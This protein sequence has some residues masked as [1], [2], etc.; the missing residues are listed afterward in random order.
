MDLMPYVLEGGTGEVT[1]SLPP[2]PRTIEVLC[3]SPQQEKRLRY[4]LRM[5]W[6]RRACT[7]R[8]TVMVPQEL[9]PGATFKPNGTF[10]YDGTTPV[11][12]YQFVIAAHD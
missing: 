2:L 10:H 3:L 4:F 5:D 11:G 1:F 7:E 9:P 12:N 8:Y 6:F